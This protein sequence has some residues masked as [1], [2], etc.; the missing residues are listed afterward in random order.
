MM[1]H[2]DIKK[3]VQKN[4]KSIFEEVVNIRRWIH[5]HPELSFQ[6]KN[7]SKYIFISQK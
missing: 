6:E 3:Q 2:E 7:T 1:K 4:T 5:K